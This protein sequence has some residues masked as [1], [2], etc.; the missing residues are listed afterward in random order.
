MA[1]HQRAWAAQPSTAHQLPLRAPVGRVS[2]LAARLRQDSL[3][4]TNSPVGAATSLPGSVVH[5]SRTGGGR[6]PQVSAANVT[7]PSMHRSGYSMVR[8]DHHSTQVQQMASG[9]ANPQQAAPFDS[10]FQRQVG[11]LEGKNAALQAQIEQLEAEKRL[12]KN[13]LAELERS[14]SKNVI[15]EEMTRRW[16]SVGPSIGSGGPL[17]QVAKEKQYVKTIEDLR[18]Q[19]I[20][21]DQELQAALRRIKESNESSSAMVAQKA[22]NAIEPGSDPVV[23]EAQ[24]INPVDERPSPGLHPPSAK[25]GGKPSSHAARGE[26]HFG[27]IGIPQGPLLQPLSL[28]DE[29]S[30]STSHRGAGGLVETLWARCA[31]SMRALLWGATAASTAGTA[32]CLGTGKYNNRTYGIPGAASTHQ[33]SSISFLKFAEGR[34]ESTPVDAEEPSQQA[35]SW[36]SL[37]ALWAAHLPAVAA[38]ERPVSM[39]FKDTV[40]LS[41]RAYQFCTKTS[42]DL[43]KGTVHEAQE[44]YAIAAAALKV[45]ATFIEENVMCRSMARASLSSIRDGGEGSS[46][47]E[48]INRCLTLSLESSYLF[49]LSSSRADDMDSDLIISEML[50]PDS[51]RG[52]GE[53]VQ[54]VVK[55]CDIFVDP[56]AGDSLSLSKQDARGMKSHHHHRN[57]S[58]PEGLLG[59]MIAVA[60][61]REGPSM[62]G[63]L[64]AAASDVALALANSTLPIH[65]NSDNS[66]R[67]MWLSLITTGALHAFLQSS[68][69]ATQRAG[70][71]LLHLLLQDPNNMKVFTGGISMVVDSPIDEEAVDDAAARKVQQERKLSAM[72]KDA[73]DETAK[74]SRRRRSFRKRRSSTSSAAIDLQ[75]VSE[76]IRAPREQSPEGVRGMPSAADAM[77]VDGFAHV[78]IMRC[79]QDI[80]SPPWQRTMGYRGKEILEDLLDVL[81]PCLLERAF[82]HSSKRQRGLLSERGECLSHYSVDD[83]A[84]VPDV[85]LLVDLH[86]RTLAILAL[87]LEDEKAEKVCVEYLIASKGSDWNESFGARSMSMMTVDSMQKSRESSEALLRHDANRSDG[88]KSPE[89]RSLSS[90]R[91]PS[92]LHDKAVSHQ[93]K[94]SMS[95]ESWAM[96]SSLPRSLPILLV[97][98]AECSM[99]PYEGDSMAAVLLLSTRQAPSGRSKWAREGQMDWQVRLRLAQE[100]LTLL[101]ALAIS[102]KLAA[103][104]L[105]EMSSTPVLGQRMLT[106][107][108]RLSRVEAPTHLALPN[109]KLGVE[110]DSFTRDIGEEA[111][112]IIFCH[113][114]ACG[115]PVSGWAHAIG[116]SSKAS[117]LAPEAMAV[118]RGHLPCCSTADV[119]YLARGV[120]QRLLHRIS[121]GNADVDVPP[122]K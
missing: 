20:F 45:V 59:L 41:I 17:Q 83:D 69:L 74:L 32:F 14:S 12:M 85:A 47:L 92:A 52:M 114:T 97:H 15:S 106:A 99:M 1:S 38:G 98:L 90:S 8:D 101:R 116:S 19:L 46:S 86:R 64:R 120:R 71:A 24:P 48:S 11:N 51:V 2:A 73:I 88:R 119:S 68:V 102:P 84:F 25:P 7:N 108:A 26:P 110:P 18:Q 56:R 94:G 104:S 118:R 49:G 89:K 113:P 121:L 13:K 36:R 117:T 43:E 60:L 79:K 105:D 16:G 112:N 3:G 42:G 22:G 29:V 109:A 80:T 75:E 58:R 115:L 40:M 53:A 27:R 77:D 61:W 95:S 82:L 23:I 72:E 122:Q 62:N 35:V 63:D 78:D 93:K 21:K 28:A 34:V 65:D 111:E 55:A 33:Q 39:V 54:E 91:P 37:R 6:D 81:N 30:M 70:V 9:H 67:E 76:T 66:L 107:L 44:A 31:S 100:C 10:N 5:V 4:F 96:K 87:M 50:W 57:L 103:V